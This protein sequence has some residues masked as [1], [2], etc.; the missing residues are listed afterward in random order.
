MAK[1]GVLVTILVMATTGGTGEAWNEVG[2]RLSVEKAIDALPRQ[3]KNFY[4][5]RQSFLLEHVED[6]AWTEP[7]LTF[8]VD[9]LTEFPFEELPENRESA[10]A[11]YGEDK[12]EEVGDL[13]WRVA[14][15]HANLVQAFK[16]L[17]IPAIESLSAEMAYYL[18]E[19]HVPVNL[20]KLGDGEPIGQ[21][22]LRE[23]FDSRAMEYYGEK[24]RIDT[25]TAIYLDRPAEY[26]ISI[27]RKSYVWVDNVLLYDYLS[28]QGVTSYDR[29]YYEGLWMRSSSLVSDLIESAARDIASFWYTAWMNAG[30]PELPKR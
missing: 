13:P 7:R 22:G 21:E 16:E 29:F 2:H 14:E 28:H 4:E 6:P 24:L 23:R 19:L 26:T 5:R 11:A 20:S 3:I 8:E 9:R 27:L 30:K 1:R 18:G 17:D 12:I 25:P 10:V 15:T